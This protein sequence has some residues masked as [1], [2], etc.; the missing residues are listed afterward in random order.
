MAICGPASRGGRLFLNAT[1]VFNKTPPVVLTSNTAMDP[2]NANPYGPM[3]SISL[4]KDF[5]TSR[6]DL[7]LWPQRLL[8]PHFYAAASAEFGLKVRYSD[9]ISRINLYDW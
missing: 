9:F 8:R 3:L 4:T 1:N 7:S 6:S 2:L 5:S